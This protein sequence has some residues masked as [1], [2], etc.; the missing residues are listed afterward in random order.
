MSQSET[1]IP[2]EVYREARLAEFS[3]IELAAELARRRELY[4]KRKANEYHYGHNVDIT[5]TPA[6]CTDC[7]VELTE[8][9]FTQA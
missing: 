4:A 6:Y 3:D 8:D 9:G 1:E 5:T 2:D 7:E